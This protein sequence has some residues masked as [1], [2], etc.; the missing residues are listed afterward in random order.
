MSYKIEDV[1]KFKNISIGDIVTIHD[2]QYV[3]LNN[4]DCNN[5]LFV[6]NRN[7]PNIFV[8]K[9]ELEEY[10]KDNVTQKSHV[11]IL[12]KIKTSRT[13]FYFHENG[14]VEVGK[15]IIYNMNDEECAL[16]F[17]PYI[18]KLYDCNVGYPY[19]V[20]EVIQCFPEKVNILLDYD[21]CLTL[22]EKKTILTSK[23]ICCIP[24]ISII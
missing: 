9:F 6:V 11:S 2:I 1:E 5:Y 24:K 10:V 22:E 21:N 4:Y 19:T 17:Y 18:G 14:Q 13:E 15:K 7:I 3:F 23:E 20:D 8:E 12:K 16:F